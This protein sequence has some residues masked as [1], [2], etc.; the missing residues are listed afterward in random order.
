MRK[1]ESMGQLRA[2]YEAARFGDERLSERL[3]GVVKAVGSSP[4]KSFPKLASSESELEGFYRFFR[5][6]RVEPEKILAPHIARTRQRALDEDAVSVVHDT[7]GFS[8]GGGGR[9]EELGRIQSNNAGFFGHFALAVSADGSHLPL[10]VL[11]FETVFRKAKSSRKL[12]S[13]QKRLRKD[14]ESARWAALVD[15]A[16]FE[17]EGASAVHVMDRDADSYAL[18]W[19]MLDRGYRF[20]VRLSHDRV[21]ATESSEEPRKVS[22]SMEETDDVLVREV[23]LSRRKGS[24]LPYSNKRFPPRNGRIAFLHVR[25]K[26]LAIQRPIYSDGQTRKSDSLPAALELNVV[27]VY[28]KSPPKGE[29][30]VRWTLITNEPIRD[31]AEVALIVDRYRDRW[32]IEEFI[33]A[34]KTGCAFEKRQLETR[35]AL[36]NAL[37]VFLPVA[38]RLLLLKTLP[39]VAP[40]APA[41][42]LLSHRQIRILRVLSPTRPLSY[43]P[44]LEEVL[45]AIARLGGHLKQN[46]PPGWQT[47]GDGFVRLLEAIAMHDLIQESGCDQS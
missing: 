19:H 47:L 3:V 20:V 27:E 42:L 16:A 34:L 44:T 5:N 31:P 36:L 35:H 26:K 30:P 37:A 18:F 17:L 1:I 12:T 4:E 21:L 46:G 40:T 24:K 23:P 41:Q 7:T 22:L 25:A 28:E 9:A 33:K 32:V 45:F 2:E 13:H 15:K 6:E 43:E 8:F 14:K 11:G 38:Y 29:D 10:G 39:R